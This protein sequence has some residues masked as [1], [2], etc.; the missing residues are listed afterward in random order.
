MRTRIEFIKLLLKLKH[1]SKACQTQDVSKVCK[2]AQLKWP[3]LTVSLRRT[4]K[5]CML[6]QESCLLNV[7]TIS[8]VTWR[9]MQQTIMSSETPI[10]LSTELKKLRSSRNLCAPSEW[11]AK[12]TSSTSCR[13]REP[14]KLLLCKYRTKSK[15]SAQFSYQKHWR[16]VDINHLQRLRQMSLRRCWNNKWSITN[17]H[18]WVTR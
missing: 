10:L 3:R 13:T 14:W 2:S 16:V 8:R 6:V 15:S 11:K 5:N 12:R 7:R 1:L 4:K 17:N 9:A 18:F